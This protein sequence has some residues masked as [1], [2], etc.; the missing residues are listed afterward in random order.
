MN[1]SGIIARRSLKSEGQAYEVRIERPREDER[2]NFICTWYLV[3]A[4]ESVLI[5]LDVGGGDS[6]QALLLAVL[7]IGERLEFWSN[8]ATYIGGQGTGFL[9]VLR[10]GEQANSIAWYFP[11]T[12]QT[13]SLEA[14]VEPSLLDPTKPAMDDSA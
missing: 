5:S 10:K 4:S 14:G 3:D 13:E 1:A 11:P 8:R 7:N 2:G 12:G 9:R 6:V